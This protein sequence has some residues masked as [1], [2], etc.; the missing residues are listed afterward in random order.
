M[1]RGK[2][3]G[4]ECAREVR[5]NGRLEYPA[6]DQTP[7]ID[8]PR[9]R[10]SAFA[11]ADWVV[12]GAQLLETRRES[13]RQIKRNVHEGSILLQVVSRKADRELRMP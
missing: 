12:H 7:Y 13:G 4:R 1:G 10:R 8:L 6:E 2:D 5:E 9:L 3:S 11:N